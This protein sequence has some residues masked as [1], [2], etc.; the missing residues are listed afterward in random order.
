MT[1]IYKYRSF[2]KHELTFK[3]GLFGKYDPLFLDL[4]VV[5]LER[6]TPYLFGASF[7]KR[8]HLNQ[9]T[10]GHTFQRDHI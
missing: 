2:G 6:M 9:E 7:Q 8:P 3:C 10:S 5:S 1:T 4:N